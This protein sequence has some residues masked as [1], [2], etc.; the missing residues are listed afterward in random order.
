MTTTQTIVSGVAGRYATA[1]FDLAKERD[2]LDTV[3]SDLS[4]LARLIAENPEFRG[5]IQSP[6]L[7]KAEQRAALFAVLDKMESHHITR[8]FVGVVMKNGRLRQLNSMIGAFRALLAEHRGEVTAEVAAPQELSEAQ[9]QSVSEMLARYAGREVH[10]EPR[11]DESLL[12]GL[13]VKMG[14]KM[15]DNSLRTKLDNLKLAMKEV[16]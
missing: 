11:V 13:V 16:G 5:V 7:D 1:L 6:V 12:G 4:G 10:I 9:M 14:S 3:E 2:A 15:I 8:N